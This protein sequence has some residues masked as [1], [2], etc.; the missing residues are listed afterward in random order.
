MDLG[1]GCVISEEGGVMA[2]ITLD[3]LLGEDHGVNRRWVLRRRP[4][5]KVR[6]EDLILVEGP[7]SPPGSGEVLLRNLYLSLDPTNRLWMSD[8]AQYLPPVGIGEVM[9]G[10]TLGLVLDSRSDRF[11]PGDLVSAGD[12]GWQ[13][14]VTCSAERL[15]RV[16]Q[17]PGLP[18]TAHL[19]IFGP[20]GLTAYFGLTDVGRPKSGETVVISAA[21]G[22]VGSIAGQIAKHIGC[23]VVGI[24]GGPEKC[25]WITEDLGFDVAIDYR[26]QDVAAELD[27]LCPHGVDIGFEN[28]G[29]AVMNAVF[30]RLNV[31][32]RMALCGMI[33]AYNQEGPMPG[34]ADFGRILMNRLTVQGFV[35]IDYLPRAKEALTYLGAMAREGQLK[36]K[37][38]VVQGLDQ[39]PDAL[40]RLFRGDHDG[41][42]LVQLPEMIA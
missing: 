40:D 39:A 9:R 30:D 7:I 4:A 14:Y 27:R 21:A 25:R 20:T 11:Q 33:S 18:L 37:V 24:A 10:G 29:G 19:S 2:D 34:P 12:G 41:K 8:R 22:A 13:D 17:A 3:R 23:H 26:A 38:D 31:G 42:L 1:G 6:Q 35:V 5:A 15:G 16:R 32:G 28:V 36:W